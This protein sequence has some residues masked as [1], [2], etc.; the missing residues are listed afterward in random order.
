MKIIIGMMMLLNLVDVYATEVR[1]KEYKNVQGMDASFILKTTLTEKVV[2][3]CQSFIHGLTIGENDNAV[4]F[5]LEEDECSGLFG[6]I[7][8]SLSKKHEHCLD[9]EDVIRSDYTCQ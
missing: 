1:V 3:D 5:M 7:K 4:L 9:I 8:N 2:L 6:R